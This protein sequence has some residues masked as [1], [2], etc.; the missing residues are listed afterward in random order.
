MSGKSNGKNEDRD[1]VKYDK[2]TPSFYKGNSINLQISKDQDSHKSTSKRR[3]NMFLNTWTITS[4]RSQAANDK[5]ISKDNAGISL[6]KSQN[7]G[8]LKVQASKTLTDKKSVDL[9]HQKDIDRIKSQ[10][11][12]ASIGENPVKDGISHVIA[13]KSLNIDTSDN[14][15]LS[16][17]PINSQPKKTSLCFFKKNYTGPNNNI[18]AVMSPNTSKMGGS[19]K[20]FSDDQISASTLRF[21]KNSY[22]GGSKRQPQVRHRQAIDCSASDS[23]HRPVI[24]SRIDR[25]ATLE[26]GSGQKSAQGQKSVQD[27]KLTFG[28]KNSDQSSNQPS[29][30]RSFGC[31]E[32]P[33]DLKYKPQLNFKDFE[34]FEAALDF[35]SR[36]RDSPINASSARIMIAAKNDSELNFGKPLN[37]INMMASSQVTVGY[38][39]QIVPLLNTS[40]MRELSSSEIGPETSETVRH[41]NQTID[42]MMQRQSHN[43]YSPFRS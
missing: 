18:Q 8:K 12:S 25:T 26:Q 16:R 2:S 20:K 43:N 29:S 10:L 39:K 31:F 6:L 24:I 28:L 5:M 32:I 14:A 38:H 37:F 15:A 9:I 4:P 22:V 33:E 23:K 11:A 1:S 19:N 34:V 41:I 30:N 21:F 27:Q 35:S 36:K 13:N 40:G 42:A 7:I 3:N 17:D